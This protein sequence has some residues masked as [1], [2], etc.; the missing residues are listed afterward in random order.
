MLTLADA[1]EQGD[2]LAPS[3]GV[4][5]AAQDES[6]APKKH[7]GVGALDAAGD[8][9]D[10]DVLFA[11]LQDAD[12]QN[13]LQPG[14]VCLGQELDDLTSDSILGEQIRLHARRGAVPF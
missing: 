7:A 5:R 10:L 13:F 11:I 1:V 12:G 8:V 6:A 4:E 2:E 9:I 14:R 3:V